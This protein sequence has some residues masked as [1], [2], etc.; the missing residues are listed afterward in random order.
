MLIMAERSGALLRNT[1]G[2]IFNPNREL[3]DILVNK[4][5]FDEKKHSF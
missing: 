2:I 1:V 3:R 4:F 5:G